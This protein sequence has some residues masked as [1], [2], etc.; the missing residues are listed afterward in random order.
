MSRSDPNQKSANPAK[1]WFSWDGAKGNLKY[2]DK[3]TEKDVHL[4]LPFWFILL[5]RLATVRGWHDPSE[6]GIY[7]NEVRRTTDE[8]FTVRAFK[9]KEPIARGFY[10]DIKDK[11]KAS[12]GKFNT[13]LYIAFIGPMDQLEIGSLMLRGAALQ[14]W[15]DFEKAN[16]KEVFQNAIKITKFEEGKKGSVT[17]RK[18]VFELTDL[19]PD[20]E[21]KA[22]ELQKHL[23]VYLTRYLSKA[24]N[25]ETTDDKLN[26]LVEEKA[27]DEEEDE[28]PF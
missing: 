24:D 12:G 23:D 5:D 15:F 7:S 27:K 2:Y 20:M 10:A 16:R 13:N 14:P 3:E 21:E 1:M 22:G 4:E 9:M 28:I 17:F 19:E 25:S 11:V 6:S 26:A 8:P 18:P